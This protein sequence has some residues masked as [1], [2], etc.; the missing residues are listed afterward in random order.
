MISVVTVDIIAGL[1]ISG[2]NS[3]NRYVIKKF[4]LGGGIPQDSLDKSILRDALHI[5][6]QTVCLSLFGSLTPCYRSQCLIINSLAVHIVYCWN[7]RLSYFVPISA[8]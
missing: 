6:L 3:I 2:E 7:C 8:R 4:F 5:T 1:Q